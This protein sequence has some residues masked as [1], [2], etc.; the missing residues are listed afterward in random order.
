MLEYVIRSGTLLDGSG[1]PG[2]E[3]DVGL[4]DGRIVAVG[5]VEEDART[6]LDATGHYQPIDLQ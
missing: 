3:A 2:R 6:E 4:R 1:G 5:R